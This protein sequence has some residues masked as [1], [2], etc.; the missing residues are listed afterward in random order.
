[1]PHARSSASNA[2]DDLAST[3][4]H[5]DRP[6]SSQ[7]ST[8]VNVPYSDLLQE[9]FPDLDPVVDD[10]FLLAWIHRLMVGGVWRWLLG[11][12]WVGFLAECWLVV[13]C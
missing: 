6:R 12:L 7:V 5:P 1:M 11:C 3:L 9:M 10:L 13:A 4:E 2:V 8:E